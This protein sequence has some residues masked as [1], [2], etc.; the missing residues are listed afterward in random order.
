MGKTMIQRVY[1]QAS[2]S[3][4]IRVVVATDN[5]SIAQH[6]HSF[7]GEVCMTRADHVSGTDRVEEVARLL[8]LDHEH[9]V[10]N[11]Q[12]DEPLIPP[13]VI[14]QVAQL[15]GDLDVP[16]AT[17]CEP[18][19]SLT[20]MLDPN[21]VKVVKD[22]LGAALYFSRAPIPWLRD[23][24]PEIYSG[25]GLRHIGLYAYKAGLLKQ[26]VMW[27]EGRLEQR[28]KLEQ[29]RVLEN[30]IKIAIAESVETIP[31]GIDTANDLE[32]TLAVLSQAK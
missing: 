13:S 14:N 27:S 31:P 19:E 22:N 4:A 26:F 30:G 11:V 23:E 17:L 1:E 16:M 3:D 15:L 6:V 25:G 18:I 32:R 5:E 9:C 21:I 7:G 2:M 28:E 29:L 8:E 12:G 24:M 10:V 20:D